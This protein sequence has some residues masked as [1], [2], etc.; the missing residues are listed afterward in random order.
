MDVGIV[1]MRVRESLVPV[2]VAMRLTRR[3]V[4]VMP[5]LVVRVVDV[6]R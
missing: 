6:H 3:I 2:G 4:R 1:R 5:V